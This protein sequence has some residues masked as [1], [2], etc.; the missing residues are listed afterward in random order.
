MDSSYLS[1]LL[2]HLRRCGW[3]MNQVTFET[4]LHANALGNHT[5]LFY[6]DRRSIERLPQLIDHGFDTVIDIIMSFRIMTIH[7]GLLQG[8]K[9]SAKALQLAS[10]IIDLALLHIDFDA[11]KTAIEKQHKLLKCYF[12]LR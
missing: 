9:A 8:I 5:N 4:T 1:L 12:L 6:I 3:Y 10:G 7:A 11:G 2:T